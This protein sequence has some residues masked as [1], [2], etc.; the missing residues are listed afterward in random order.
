M[1]VTVATSATTSSTQFVT[2][3]VVTLVFVLGFVICLILFVWIRSRFRQTGKYRVD[4]V[5][6]MENGHAEDDNTGS[7]H[8]QKSM[9]VAPMA[10]ILRQT[11]I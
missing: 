6:V 5:A 7:V 9:E 4:G 3:L 8:V 10:T 11:E 2:A 1:V